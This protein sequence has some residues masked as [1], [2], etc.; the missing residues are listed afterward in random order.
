MSVPAERPSSSECVRLD[1][2][3][4]RFGRQHVVRDVSLAIDGGE[5]VCVRGHNGA[6]KTT[7]LRLVAGAIRPTRGVRLG[8][9][10]SAYV[11]PALTPPVLTVSG[12]LRG[13]RRDRVE[14]PGHALET[15]GFDG[16]LDH[17]CRELSF[18]NLRK[19]LLAD[20]FTSTAPLLAIDEVH[21]GIDHAGR[22]GLERL[23]AQARA[24][25]AAV[26]V[27]AQDDDEVD[28]VERTLV[29]GDGLVRDD[30]AGGAD[31]TND[32]VR[33][34]LR[35]PRSAEAELLAAAERLGFRPDEAGGR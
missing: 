12:W 1:A 29:I 10:S 27:A 24:R 25:G 19:V 17:S 18:G 14:D 15:L 6:G 5:H 23:V 31:S 4:V 35:G 7:L 20:A 32:V 22:V 8:P 33:R 26:V 2:V 9:R 34:T 16:D 13:V 3:T 21:V 30:V 28:G 11:P